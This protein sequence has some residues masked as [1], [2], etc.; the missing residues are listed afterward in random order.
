MDEYYYTTN[1]M[2]PAEPHH[3]CPRF[4]YASE[5]KERIEE[6]ETKL[7]IEKLLVDDAIK[8]NRELERLATQRGERMRIMRDY[9]ITTMDGRS[10]LR[11]ETADWW[12]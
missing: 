6:L 10:F 7:A 12:W 5:A 11:T 9:L 3:K 8:H 4:V 1:G 2:I